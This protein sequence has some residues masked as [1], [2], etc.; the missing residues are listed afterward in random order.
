MP[1][2]DLRRR[3]AWAPPRAGKKTPPR[4]A[5]TRPAAARNRGGR[6]RRGQLRRRPGGA[7]RSQALEAAGDARRGRP[8]LEGPHHGHILL[9][10]ALQVALAGG[11]AQ[12]G[13]AVEQRLRVGGWGGGVGWGGVGWGGVGWGGV[14]WGGVG[15]G[16]VGCRW[17]G[18]GWG[19]GGV[20]VGWGV[21]GRGVDAGRLRGSSA[22]P[23]GA[24]DGAGAAPAPRPPA[25]GAGRRR[26]PPP[27]AAPTWLALLAASVPLR[28]SLAR[29]SSSA[30]SS[31]QPPPSVDA[32]AFT[33]PASSWE[34][35]RGGAV[36]GTRGGQGVGRESGARP[37]AAAGLLHAAALPASHAAN[38]AWHPS[39]PPPRWPQAASSAA[40]PT[41]LRQ[42]GD[43][44]LHRDQLPLQL[45]VLKALV[46]GWVGV[47]GV[48]RGCWV[49]EASCG[50][51]REPWLRTP[52]A[53]LPARRARRAE[54][55]RAAFARRSARP[56]GPFLPC[57][58][59]CVPAHLH[60]HARRLLV[61]G[62]ALRTVGLRLGQQ[63]L[64]WGEGVWGGGGWGAL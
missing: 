14:G 9:L 39:T 24:A 8:L 10:A 36:L 6:R 46:L 32:A 64:I 48:G 21:G 63:L 50:A 33:S 62:E 29:R 25:V 31:A 53:R 26:P 37:S 5:R 61:L 42:L 51:P 60:E 43:R 7:R 23:A 16:G 22:P 28:V 41:R 11:G 40:P 52:R 4:G 13:D 19:G 54:A 30:Q 49:T 2:R 3:E 12:P 45:L 20:G 56:P 17:G 38:P 58:T 35:A 55:P 18:V 57:R 15:W 44:L 47:G 59:Q 1:G 27:G 34:P